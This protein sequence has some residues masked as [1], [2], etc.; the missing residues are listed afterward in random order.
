MDDEEFQIIPVETPKV[1][2]EVPRDKLILFIKFAEELGWDKSK[3]KRYINAALRLSKLEREAGK[4]YA[5]LLRDYNR[6]SSEE[7]KLRYSIE[8]LMEKR[9]RIEE[10]LNLYLEQYKLTLEL[11]GKLTGLI[12]ALRKRGLNIDDLEK[13]LNVVES[14]RGAGYDVQEIIR[15]IEEQRDL[16]SAINELKSAL[17]GV[18]MEAQ[19]L[20]ERRQSILNEIEEIHGIAG[21]LDELKRLKSE[22]EREIQDVRK[23][24]GEAEARLEEVNAELERRLSRKASLEELD[25][26]IMQLKADAEKLKFENEKLSKELSELLGIQGGIEEIKRKI[27]EERG[28]LEGLEREISSRE[29]Y[30]EI[31]E[32]ELSAAHTM[33]KLFTDPQ[34][35]EVEDLET[36]VDQLQRIVKI[37][38]GELAALKPLEPHLL[39]RVRENIISLVLPY[40][41]NE[42]VPK[43]VFEQLEKEVKRLE[44]K[45]VAL[46][47]ELTSLRR[48]LEAK[49]EEA[50]APPPKESRIEAFTADGS[51]LDLKNLD[52]GKKIRII[53]PS[54]K[55]SVVMGIPP[56]EELEELASNNC[57]LVFTCGGCGKSFD[58]SIQLLLKKVEG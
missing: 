46:E 43:K 8:Q 29:A 20:H 40:V 41:R 36:L 19:Q 1:E 26:L 10:D 34:G 45:R 15:M 58:V 54:C 21:E 18:K 33:L 32:G 23:R 11:V 14:L 7:V 35:I 5:S 24:L 56:K 37:K 55:S 25:G 30:L 53:C 3:I 52:K 22:L 9:K 51:P 27:E 4:S 2:V 13:T 17:E 38:R 47:E 12:D 39:N 50:P 48:A 49:R 31:L 42:F 6:L 44:E 16:A 28:K 57:R